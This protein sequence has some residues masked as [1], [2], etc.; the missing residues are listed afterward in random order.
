MSTFTA[1]QKDRTAVLLEQLVPM[2]VVK[3]SDETVTNST[4]LQTDDELFIANIPVGTWELTGGLFANGISSAAQDVKYAFSFPTG[5]LTWFGIGLQANWGNLDGS[6]DISAE[7]VLA[8]SSSPTTAVAFGTVTSTNVP[9]D[10]RGV[11]TNTAAGTVGLQ[12]A[13]NTAHLTGTIL[14]AGSWLCLRKLVIV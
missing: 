9:T 12:W 8:V 6:R 3:G 13:Q 14:K 5:T 4:T 7:G 11:L 10:I 1:G 2:Y